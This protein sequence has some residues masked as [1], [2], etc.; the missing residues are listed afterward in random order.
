MRASGCGKSHLPLEQSYSKLPCPA[1]RW[2]SSN[3]QKKKDDSISAVTRNRKPN[4]IGRTLLWEAPTTSRISQIAELMQFFNM[5]LFPLIARS[6]ALPRPSSSQGKSRR[7]QPAAIIQ[8]LVRKEK[9][10]CQE[11][12]S[13]GFGN[14]APLYS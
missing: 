11:F 10:A 13:P 7:M 6:T 2:A 1:G 9:R 12:V 3:T 4:R 14:D 8:F 5:R